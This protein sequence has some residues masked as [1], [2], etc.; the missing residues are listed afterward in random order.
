MGRGIT[1][2]GSSNSTAA[3]SDICPA[4]W[5]LPNHSEMSSISSGYATDFNADSSGGMYQG[6]QQT[7]SGMVMYWSSDAY[8]AN[9]RRALD[10]RTGANINPNNAGY[11]YYGEYTRCIAN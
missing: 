1:I 7:G 10:Y 2:T 4:G 9:L 6:G 8:N 3:T 5:H 11:R